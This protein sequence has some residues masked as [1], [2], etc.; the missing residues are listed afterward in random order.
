MVKASRLRCEYLIDPIGIDSPAPRLSWELGTGSPTRRGARQ[1]AY[2]IVVTR[3]DGKTLWDSGRVASAASS[4]VRY[5]GPSLQP[6]ARY[7]W[8]VQAWNEKGKAGEWSAPASWTMGLWAP[9]RYSGIR[10]PGSRG[11][12]PACWV[13]PSLNG[14]WSETESQPSPYLRKTFTLGGT[15]R[16]AVL[17]ASALGVYEAL[18]NGS[19][20][21]ESILAPEWTDYHTKVQYQGYDV[22]DV[23]REG[24][25]VL[26]AVLGPGWYAGQLG[27]GTHFMGIQRGF[28]G[29]LLRF[30]AFLLVELEAGGETVVVTDGSWKCTT[31]G[32]IRASDILGGETYDARGRCRDG[33][34][35]DSMRRAGSP[36][37]FPTVRSWWRSPTSPSVSPRTSCRSRSRSRPPARS[38]S[39]WVRTWWAGCGPGFPAPPGRT[40][41]SVTARC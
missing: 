25:N 5:G 19:R 12:P 22:T 13:G 30:A 21:G 15:P 40:C 35:R 39:T 14:T 41:G 9:G 20:V 29:R 32:P 6:C 16:R 31:E 8:K 24:E 17:F 33:P 23:L 11:L 10:E 3:D 1:S 4:Q 27:L 36:L 7:R 34:R 2:R 38:S 18:I 26:A 37:P 28:Y